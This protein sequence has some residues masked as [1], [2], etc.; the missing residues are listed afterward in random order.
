MDFLVLV[1]FQLLGKFHVRGSCWGFHVENSLYVSLQILVA[2]LP[3]VKLCV[4]PE[5]FA[6]EKLILALYLCSI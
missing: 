5:K 1:L 3:N 2:L 6:C 4:S